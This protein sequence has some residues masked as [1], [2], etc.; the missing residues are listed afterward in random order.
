MS[1]N[2]NGT[3]PGGTGTGAG[4]NQSHALAGYLLCKSEAQCFFAGN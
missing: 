2:G 3:Q 4:N 1:N